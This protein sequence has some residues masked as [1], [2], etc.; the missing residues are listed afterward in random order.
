[1]GS[2]EGM[3]ACASAALAAATEQCGALLGEVTSAPRRYGF[4]AT[5]DPELAAEQVEQL[6]R[7]Q[8]E[9][10]QDM[11]QAFYDCS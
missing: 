11:V 6:A 3:A 10:D 7:R 1:M 9:A 5:D 8:Q 4:E 2:V